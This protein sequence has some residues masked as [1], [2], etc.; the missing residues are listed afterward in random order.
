MYLS[1][2]VQKL[3]PLEIKSHRD[4]GWVGT[5]PEKSNCTETNKS[6]R[7]TSPRKAA[8]DAKNANLG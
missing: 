7:S 3:Y 6:K 2:P 1:R 5:V 4:G 8:L